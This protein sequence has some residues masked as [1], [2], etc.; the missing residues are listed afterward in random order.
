LDPKGRV[1]NCEEIVC[2][3]G[4]AL[5]PLQSD[6]VAYQPRLA[7]NRIQELQNHR[8]ESCL[9]AVAHVGDAVLHASHVLS[10]G[11]AFVT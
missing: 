6:K 4:C 3:D 1:L 8:T 10:P 5:L 9:T 11:P 7:A 2:L